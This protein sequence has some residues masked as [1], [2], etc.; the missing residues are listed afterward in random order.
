MDHIKIDSILCFALN[1]DC[2][3][4]VVEIPSKGTSKMSTVLILRD[5][6]GRYS[7]KMDMGDVQESVV[8]QKNIETPSSITC[9][10][11]DIKDPLLGV[12]RSSS[13]LLTSWCTG[14]GSHH[15]EGVIPGEGNTN[16]IRD[17]V[18][19]FG[20]FS[21]SDKSPKE[22]AAVSGTDLSFIDLM[23]NQVHLEKAAKEKPKLVFEKCQPPT[24]MD[25][26]TLPLNTSRRML[27][28]TGLLSLSN[29]G[30]LTPLRLSRNLFDD[31]YAIDAIPEREV[32]HVSHTYPNT[33]FMSL[34]L[35]SW[36]F[37]T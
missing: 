22:S 2:L 12:L 11:V 30:A 3:M 7:W 24:K 14:K 1:E 36:L 28:K 25:V 15:P 9:P 10:P 35:P 20:E 29:W 13:S 6:T 34:T 32:T 21:A 26:T 23:K 19:R 5:P 8:G 4:T 31:I 17:L 27:I 18:V 33:F 16:S 37:Y